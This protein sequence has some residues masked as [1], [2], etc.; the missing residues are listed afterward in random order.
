MLL[1]YKAQRWPL[2][3][4]TFDQRERWRLLRLPHK[5]R[6]SDLI[7]PCR[8]RSSK[9]SEPCANQNNDLRRLRANR[10]FRFLQ[11]F[12]DIAQTIDWAWRTLATTITNC[13]KEKDASYPRRP[14][15]HS[16]RRDG[17][18]EEELYGP[19]QNTSI[20]P[21]LVA[22]HLKKNSRRDAILLEHFRART[23][24]R[25]HRQAQRRDKEDRAVERLHLERG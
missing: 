13:T 18:E 22:Y 8:A 15:P 19:L 25:E 2:P 21:A 20:R 17:D 3:R 6:A 24:W 7:Y 9:R 11:T 16:T 4:V 10:T 14:P 1:V 23:G 5:R 12:L